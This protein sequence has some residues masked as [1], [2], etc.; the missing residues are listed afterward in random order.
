MQSLETLKDA[1]F[2]LAAPLEKI[3]GDGDAEVGAMDFRSGLLE[4]GELRRDQT[5]HKKLASMLKSHSLKY[6]DQ[7]VAPSQTTARTLCAGSGAGKVFRKMRVRTEATRPDEEILERVRS[8]FPA[9]FAS[10]TGGEPLF[11]GTTSGGPHVLLFDVSTRTA[12]V[13]HVRAECPV[14]SFLL[15]DPGHERGTWLEGLVEMAVGCWLQRSPRGELQLH[16]NAGCST[17]GVSR[18]VVEWGLDLHWRPRAGWNFSG[19]LKSASSALAAE[20]AGAEAVDGKWLPRKE[21]SAW[22]LATAERSL[23]H[24]RHPGRGRPGTRSTLVEPWKAFTSER[25][26]NKR[27][28]TVVWAPSGTDRGDEDEEEDPDGTGPHHSQLEQFLRS[29]EDN[30]VRWCYERWGRSRFEELFRGVLSVKAL[31]SWVAPYAVLKFAAY[32]LHKDQ[33]EFADAFLDEQEVPSLERWLGATYFG[34]P[35]FFPPRR[36]KARSGSAV[37]TSTLLGEKIVT[38]VKHRGTVTRKNKPRTKTTSP[39]LEAFIRSL[40]FRCWF[41]LRDDRKTALFGCEDGPKEG[42]RDRCG[43]FV[44]HIFSD[45]RLAALAVEQAILQTQNRLRNLSMSSATTTSSPL[46]LKSFRAAPSSEVG[47]EA[48]NHNVHNPRIVF[49]QLIK[50]L[51]QVR[52]LTDGRLFAWNPTSASSSQSMDTQHREQ[53]PATGADEEDDPA[54]AAEEEEEAFERMK[55]LEDILGDP[56]NFFP[57]HPAVLYHRVFAHGL[58]ISSI[59]WKEFEGGEHPFCEETPQT[60]NKLPELLALPPRDY[61]A[62][63]EAAVLLLT[64]PTRKKAFGS[65]PC[66]LLGDA[67]GIP[68]PVQP[69]DKLRP[70]GQE[71]EFYV[72]DNKYGQQKDGV[73][74]HSAPSKTNP[75][76]EDWVTVPDGLSDLAQSETVSIPDVVGLPDD[77]HTPAASENRDPPDAD[78]NRGGAGV[79]EMNGPQAPEETPLAQGTR[80]VL[81]ARPQYVLEFFVQYLF[82]ADLDRGRRLTRVTTTL[83]PERAYVDRH[84]YYW[85]AR[86]LGIPFPSCP[87][88]RARLEIQ[89]METALEQNI[90]RRPDLSLGLRKN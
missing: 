29:E 55:G 45:S 60:T 57:L 40:D 28:G 27:P 61:V 44:A 59:Q 54:R 15:P 10:K 71:G 67:G 33:V 35:G 22:W 85:V 1:A 77:I 14:E 56:R 34:D 42:L 65:R 87:R 74:R 51:D 21:K 12:V 25:P 62:L 81:A 80:V 16:K 82:G 43:S 89:Q 88:L 18:D 48:K 63:L 23:P 36:K 68:I 32:W 53:R 5:S 70:H 4:C 72:A 50:F 64:K 52:A 24:A 76:M 17:G 9:S 78:E 75:N 86:R 8:R 79:G 6:P 31:Q 3:S 26:E 46:Q 83:G 73:V 37:A 90:G 30:N 58:L 2:A 41:G 13:F 49:S 38:T 84:L 7:F 47:G 39:R 19:V 66:T 20:K 69:E 11:L